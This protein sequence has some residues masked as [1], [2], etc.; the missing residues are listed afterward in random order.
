MLRDLTQSLLDLLFP[1][2][3]LTCGATG[4]VLCTACLTTVRAPRPPFCS[5]CGHPLADATRA[6]ETCASGH[7]PAALMTLRAAVVYDG[8]ARDALLAL[9]YGKRK[10]LANPLGDLLA[11]TV[12][13][14]GY[15]PDIVVPVPLHEQR[16][17]ERGYNQAELLA[18]RCASRL[19][20]SCKPGLLLRQRMT[21][22]QVGLSQAERRTNVA[23]A[24]VLVSSAAAAQLRGKRVLLI[25]DI[26]T[27][28]STMDA[29]AAAL[30]RCGCAA[31]RGLAVARPSMGD[32]AYEL[33]QARNARN[34]RYTE[35]LI[36]EKRR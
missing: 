10:R 12:Q 22:P 5:R 30:A 31:L 13:R 34:G 33:R 26:T 14:E 32:D 35:A 15:R 28:G 7:G 29:A 4:A 25:D 36:R 1:P 18:R 6:C 19:G 27:T 23:A 16:R 21:R 8:V 2:H 9:K 24:F 11:A 17:R 20:V 3:C